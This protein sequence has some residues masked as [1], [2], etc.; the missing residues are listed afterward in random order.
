ML[1]LP[2][3]SKSSVCSMLWLLYYWGFP[4]CRLAE[5][6]IPCTRPPGCMSSTGSH[7]INRADIKGCCLWNSCT[8][9][10]LLP[11]LVAWVLREGARFCVLEHHTFSSEEDQMAV[12]F[13]PGK[14]HQQ[15]TS[16]GDWKCEFSCK[17]ILLH[18]V[19]WK[20]GLWFSFIILPGS[21]FSQYADFLLHSIFS[22][23]EDY[24]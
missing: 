11:G 14:C 20:R 3:L 24:N 7:H 16:S 8:Q 12:S 19:I 1:T 23:Q 4:R 5:S 9:S 15:Q 10:W 17:L 13:S 18:T 2:W 6:L 21:M 22:G